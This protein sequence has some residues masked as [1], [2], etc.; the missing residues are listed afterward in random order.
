[1]DFEGNRSVTDL[2]FLKKKE[3]RQIKL[4][5]IFAIF[6]GAKLFSKRST[7]PLIALVALEMFFYLQ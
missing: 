6:P 7:N 5:N 3:K 4:Q 2:F 1:L